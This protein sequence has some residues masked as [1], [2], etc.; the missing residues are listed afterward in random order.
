MCKDKLYIINISFFAVMN[1]FIPLEIED[2]C[3]LIVE[4]IVAARRSGLE[5][6]RIHYDNPLLVM[7]LKQERMWARLDSVL[8]DNKQPNCDMDYSSDPEGPYI[9]FT[10]LIAV[11]AAENEE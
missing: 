9:E 10:P 4:H 1:Y 3:E 11:L 6:V 8:K 5:R 2:P 7:Q